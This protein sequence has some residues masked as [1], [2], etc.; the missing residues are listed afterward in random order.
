MVTKSFLLAVVVFSI[1]CTYVVGGLENDD[2]R[3]PFLRRRAELNEQIDDAI[4]SQL[5]EM[6]EM[7]GFEDEEGDF[8]FVGQRR[9][10]WGFSWANLLCKSRRKWSLIQ[11][12]EPYFVY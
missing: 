6:I 12:N 11:P 1:C 10:L 4:E 9:E 5:I 8:D 7:D 3:V 2:A